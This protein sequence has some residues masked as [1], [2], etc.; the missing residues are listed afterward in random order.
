[1]LLIATFAGL[2]RVGVGAHYPLDV[3]TGALLGCVCG[4]FGVLVASKTRIFSW[5][6]SRVGLLV[7]A[8]F[9]AVC[10][11]IML[12]H[13]SKYNLLVCYLAL[14]SALGCLFVILRAY[15][16]SISNNQSAHKKPSQKIPRKQTQSHLL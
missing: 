4:V 10:V 2:S 14:V 7:F 12:K 6:G 8:L 1:M 3:L 13:I 16:T 9:S 5:L 15:F 11:V